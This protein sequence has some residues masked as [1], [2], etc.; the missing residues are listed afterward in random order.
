MLNVH[1]SYSAAGLQWMLS[2]ERSRADFTKF[3]LGDPD[4]MI[5]QKKDFSFNIDSVHIT[6]DPASICKL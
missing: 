2:D 4:Q 5:S 3:G 1:I 6:F